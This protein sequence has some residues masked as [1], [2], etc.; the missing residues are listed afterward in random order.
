M[1]SGFILLGIVLLIATF[2][3]AKLVWDHDAS[4]ST[5]D[6]IEADA[7]K[8]PDWILSWGFFDVEKGVAPLN[9]RQFGN[10]VMV[11]KE[12]TKVEKDAVLMQV[13]DRL[14][15]LKVKEAKADMDAST[16][17]VALAKQLTRLYELQRTEQQSAVNA[18]DLEKKKLEAK[19]DSELLLLGNPND[20]ARRE[21]VE[22][23]YH[24]AF[25]QLA[26][27]KKAEEAKL[28]QVKLQDATLKIA[29]AEADL[30]A[31]N[32]RLN[33]AKEML[34]HFVV[35]APSDGTILR[36]YVHKGETM[37]PNPLKPAMEFLPKSPTIVKAEVL[38]EWGRFVKEGQAVE[39]E[40]DT[41]HGLTWHGTVKT[42]SKWYAPPR[43][44]VLEPFRLN[45]V[46]TLEVIISVNDPAGAPT[47]RN[48]QRV[49][50]KIKVAP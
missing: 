38:Q 22:E 16:Q 10:I 13:D 15:D 11:E 42:V 1:K 45:D 21:K 26:E 31:K 3:G 30:E 47:P 46:R 8:P 50:A 41:Y 34:K 19:R 9:P 48:G 12:N 32:V 20:K 33:Q 25:D 44:V 4:A 28:E 29:Q 35:T 17:Q 39:I 5:K 18:L 7:N 23:L 40:D 2:F 36:V 14:A 6:K 49:R 24:F 43:S 37:G 27:K